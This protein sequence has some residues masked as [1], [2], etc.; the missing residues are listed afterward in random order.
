MIDHSNNIKQHVF[1]TL[2]LLRYRHSTRA[3]NTSWSRAYTV[4]YTVQFHF[5][6][7]NTNI[8]L[9][10]FEVDSY[11][12]IYL[13][14]GKH[15][16]TFLFEAL[17]R[18]TMCWKSGSLKWLVSCWSRFLQLRRKFTNTCCRKCR[19][20]RLLRAL[21]RSLHALWANFSALPFL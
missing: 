5:K 9:F 6:P 7:K 10:Y 2:I 19:V 12:H 14:W 3:L 13:L 17:G 21:S 1:E 20:G 8:K 15:R 18:Q 4:L 16:L 11:L